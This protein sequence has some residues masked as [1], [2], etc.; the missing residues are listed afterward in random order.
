MNLRAKKL[1]FSRMFRPSFAASCS[2][3]TIAQVIHRSVPVRR[4]PSSPPD[5]TRTIFSD[6]DTVSPSTSNDS[7]FPR[8]TSS[9]RY[10][11]S[12]LRDDDHLGRRCPPSTPITPFVR[13]LP[14]P[15]VPSVGEINNR[16]R[17]E[18]TEKKATKE[19][20]KEKCPY[21]S[22]TTSR[23]DW[24]SS[25]DESDARLS[26]SRSLSSD[27]S[28]TRRRR[29]RRRRSGAAGAGA[30]RLAGREIEDSFAVVKR[31]SDPRGDFRQSMVEMIVEKEMFGAEELQKLLECFLALNSHHHHR[32]I[33]QVFAEIWEVL[34]SSRS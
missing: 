2:S 15:P 7:R 3:R 18:H 14:R 29:R 9:E 20:E 25:D 34:F 6:S 12:V 17:V 10:P 8:R 32:V 27:S 16:S 23:E 4:P 26:S 11:P 1:R 31:S 13:R 28:E 5:S 21:S 30:P 22:S 19:E 33:L 24:F